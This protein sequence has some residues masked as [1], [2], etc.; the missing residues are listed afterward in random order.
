ML[1]LINLL[2]EFQANRIAPEE[3]SRKFLD[4]WR[5]LRDEQYTLA[6]QKPE[7]KKAQDEL[8]AKRLADEIGPDA[9]LAEYRPI[10][11]ELYRDC[12]IK[13]FS[14]EEEIIARLFAATE[15]YYPPELG[16]GGEVTEAELYEVAMQ[17]LDDLTS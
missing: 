15:R 5:A 6:E 13:A 2:R 12:T 14:R 16:E 17:A 10:A 7:F 4:V 8:F 11:E 1:P 3:F 9:F